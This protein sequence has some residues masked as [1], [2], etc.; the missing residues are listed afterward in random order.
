MA[1]VWSARA[2]S[3]MFGLCTMLC[4]LG[5]GL[6]NVY[7]NRNILLAAPR[8]RSGAAGG[9]QGVAR[10][11]GQM[12]GAVMITLL[13]DLSSLD[14]ASR[15]RLAIGAMLT[16]LAGIMSLLRNGPPESAS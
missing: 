2:Q 3:F 1:A 5:F 13:F 4:G 8:E 7:S 14:V 16:M 12:V 9:L 6:F 11:T 15:I 10:L